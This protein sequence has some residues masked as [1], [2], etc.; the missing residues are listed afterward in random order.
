MYLAPNL[1][2]F[3]PLLLAIGTA[4]FKYR[5]VAF[6][7]LAVFFICALYTGNLSTWSLAYAVIGL[8]L[9]WKVQKLNSK[10]ALV[11]HVFVIIWCLALAV[12]LIPGF[13]NVQVL[14]NVTSG[15][16]STSF[17]MY[18]NLDK[19]LLFFALLLMYPALPGTPKA[20]QVKPLVYSLVAITCL[21][22]LASL[23]GAIQPELTLPHWW[24]LFAINNL[25][26]T[27]VA[28]EAFF[29]GYLQQVTSK[30]WGNYVG[31]AVASVLFGLAHF[32]GGPLFILF[33]T[34]AGLG[35]GLVFHFT[36]RLWAAVL[37]HF[38]FNFA[39]LVF[40]TYPL[41]L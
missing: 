37:T 38:V 16:G 32:A 1:W 33:A 24:W 23:S 7:A 8:L 27:C 41:A 31:I 29:R 34:L 18:F 36:G 28:E 3:L 26:L 10:S 30:L 17:N 5:L 25:M 2:I 21:L 19:P 4:L 9:A 13:N 40:F 6:S 20:I 35:Y 15:P 11:G 39:H 22:P 14:D 12:H